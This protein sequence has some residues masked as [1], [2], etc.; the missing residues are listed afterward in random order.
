MNKT[1]NIYS[2]PSERTSLSDE[3]IKDML[4]GYYSSEGPRYVTIDIT[5][6]CNLRCIGCWTYSPLLKTKPKPEWYQN[7]LS[8]ETIATLVRSLSHLG[9]KEIRITGG[10]EPLMHTKFKDIVRLI[11]KKGISCDLTTNFTLMTKNMID[12][13]LDIGIDNITASIWS[14]DETSYEE[15]HPNSGKYFHYIK[16]NLKYLSKKRNTKNKKTKIVIANVINSK[17]YNRI[18][19][20]V[21]FDEEIGADEVYFTFHDPIKD[22]TQSLV[23]NDD[24][25]KKIEQQFIKIK[26]MKN[27]G[28]IKIEIDSLDKLIKISKGIGFSK[29]KYY[30]HIMPNNCFVPWVFSRIFAN[31][32]VAPCCKAIKNILGNINKSDFKNIWNSENMKKFRKLSSEMDK[33][34]VKSVGCDK[35]CDNAYENNE[36]LKSLI[37][38]RIHPSEIG[39][40]KW[41]FMPKKGKK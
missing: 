32:D 39:K 11:K 36:I 34:I 16:E 9:T 27:S 12:F 38:H 25:R 20:I 26:E 3:K 30:S 22:Q 18:I 15:Q 10:G 35:S 17:N 40:I 28:K 5:N 7:E 37:E 19:D 23:P 21:K 6:S 29:A 33:S 14:A 1:Q 41:N 8:Y 24:Q 4:K 2:S 13:L 31:G